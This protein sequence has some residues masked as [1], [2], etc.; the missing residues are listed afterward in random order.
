MVALIAWGMAEVHDVPTFG[1]TRQAT[2]TLRTAAC[3]VDVVVA[4][5]SSTLETCAVGLAGAGARVV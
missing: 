3:S 2:A 1:P 4:R 5:G